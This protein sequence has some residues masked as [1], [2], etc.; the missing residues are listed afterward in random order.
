MC[1]EK[2]GL[3]CFCIRVKEKWS[4][5]LKPKVC[6]APAVVWGWTKTAEAPGGGGDDTLCAIPPPPRGAIQVKDDHIL[7]AIMVCI[8]GRKQNNLP[9]LQLNSKLI[10]VMCFTENCLENGSACAVDSCQLVHMEINVWGMFGNRSN[11]KGDKP[12]MTKDWQRVCSHNL[13]FVKG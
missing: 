5:N 10:V 11:W 8:S 12:I 7:S 13:R 2:E 3:R 1:V 4:I 9:T 6:V